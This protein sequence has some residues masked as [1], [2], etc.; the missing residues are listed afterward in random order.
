MAIL[1][2]P[3]LGDLSGVV[4]NAVIQKYRNQYVVKTRQ[5]PWDTQQTTKRKQKQHINLAVMSSFLAE[6]RDVIDCGYQKNYRNLPARA[7]AMKYNLECALLDGGDGPVPD[8][9]EIKFSRGCR[10]P[11]WSASMVRGGEPNEVVVKWEIPQTVKLKEVR[12][13]KA[14]LIFWNPE[15]N[16]EFEYTDIERAALGIILPV[17]LAVQAVPG[18]VIHGWIFFVSPD[19]K[20]VSD[21]DYLG[22]LVFGEPG[23]E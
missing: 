5:V 9:P 17:F 8:Y 20:E 19:G 18:A 14:Y 16:K 23:T 4:G 15:K 13:D 21:T 11:A 7:Q 3:L 22:S 1:L 12:N 6:F 2:K 10:E